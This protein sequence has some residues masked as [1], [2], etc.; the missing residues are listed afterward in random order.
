MDTKAAPQGR[1][2]REKEEWGC[3]FKGRSNSDGRS[4]GRHGSVSSQFIMFTASTKIDLH[5]LDTAVRELSRSSFE[6]RVKGVHVNV[7]YPCW[8]AQS[9]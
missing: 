3:G 5:D 2:V 4:P 8:E 6:V 9:A 1:Y 7:F